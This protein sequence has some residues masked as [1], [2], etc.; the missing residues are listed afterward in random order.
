MWKVKSN[1]SLFSKTWFKVMLTQH[2][3]YF[4]SLLCL[5]EFVSC[6]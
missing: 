4:I 3:S 2:V 6:H 1:E 5:N